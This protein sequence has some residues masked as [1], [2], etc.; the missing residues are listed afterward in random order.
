MERGALQQPL[1]NRRYGRY[2]KVLTGDTKCVAAIVEHG[3][4]HSPAFVKILWPVIKPYQDF[5]KT[6]NFLPNVCRFCSLEAVSSLANSCLSFFFFWA[7]KN[8]KNKIFFFPTLSFLDVHTSTPQ[9]CKRKMSVQ[10]CIF[11]LFGFKRGTFIHSAHIVSLCRS[12]KY[13]HMWTYP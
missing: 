7:K 10:D 11:F 6:E 12:H 4:L 2:R 9:I 3:V 8:K 5:H 13:L 1:A